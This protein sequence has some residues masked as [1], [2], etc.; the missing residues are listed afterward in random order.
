MGKVYVIS[1][2]GQDYYDRF[3]VY[4]IYDKLDEA[5]AKAEELRK[6]P[7]EEPYYPDDL[8]YSEVRV[9]TWTVL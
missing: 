1:S 6:L 8:E 3:E 2:L 9:E 4:A 5:E 7:A